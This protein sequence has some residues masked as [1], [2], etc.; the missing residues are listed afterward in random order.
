MILPRALPIIMATL[1]SSNLAAGT[2]CL[3]TCAMG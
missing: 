2:R 3:G 1:P